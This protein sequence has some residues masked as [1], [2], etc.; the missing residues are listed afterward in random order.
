[1]VVTA[2]QPQH[3][4]FISTGHNIKPGA[5]SIKA[6][7]GRCASHRRLV[8]IDRLC[9]SI[10]ATGINVARRVEWRRQKRTPVTAEHFERGSSRE[11][12]STCLSEIRVCCVSV[13]KGVNINEFLIIVYEQCACQC[14]CMCVK[15]EWV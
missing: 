2:N 3:H 4:T 8:K 10:F 14:A 5:C 11:G 12:L 15:C 13:K 9:S 7:F 6:L 1:M